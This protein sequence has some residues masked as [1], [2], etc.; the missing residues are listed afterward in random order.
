MVLMNGLFGARPPEAGADQGTINEA[1][2]LAAKGQ[3][4]FRPCKW[5]PALILIGCF[6]KPVLLS[7]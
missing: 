1:S 5:A 3:A 7:M 2:P 6:R 4:K